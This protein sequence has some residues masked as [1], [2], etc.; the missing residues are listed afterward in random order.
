MKTLKITTTSENDGQKL[1]IHFNLWNSERNKFLCLDIGIMATIEDEPYKINLNIPGKYATEKRPED[2]VED[3]G[4]ILIEKEKITSNIFNCK[5][6]FDSGESDGLYKRVTKEKENESFI[7]HKFTV[8]EET[9]NYSEE[10]ECMELYFNIE[11]EGDY[12]GIKKIYY[13]VRVNDFYLAAFSIISTLKNKIFNS[14]Y[15]VTRILDF[16]INDTKLMELDEAHEFM[17]KRVSFEKVHFF[18]ICDIDVNLLSSDKSVHSRLF[19]KSNWNDYINI[20][21]SELMAYHLSVKKANGNEEIFCPSF[22]LQLKKSKTS[23]WHILIYALVVIIL[24]II[25]N[26]ISKLLF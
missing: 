7:L 12:K 19:E 23:I 17:K 18:Y 9:V 24:A 1:E 5:L 25:A 26:V 21:K 10:K 11:K 16:R 14:Q 20:N 15:D 8:S 22:L 6:H 13:R 2:L 3:L 4:H